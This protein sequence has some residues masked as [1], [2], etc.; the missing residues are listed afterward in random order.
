MNI[1]SAFGVKANQTDQNLVGGHIILHSLR[2]VSF[3]VSAVNLFVM[4]SPLLTV[5]KES[6]FKFLRVVAAVDA[7]F[8]LLLFSIGLQTNQCGTNDQ[9]KCSLTL[10]FSFLAVLSE[11]L[12]S[13]LALLNIQ[14]EIFITLRKILLISSSKWHVVRNANVRT[15]LL[16]FG[17]LS[18]IVCLP[19]LLIFKVVRKTE[20][21]FDLSRVIL[22]LDR[23]TEAIRITAVCPV[24]LLLTV[25]ATVRYHRYFR[26]KNHRFIRSGDIT[27]TSKTKK[28]KI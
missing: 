5:Q 16:F 25:M 10:E 11:Y 1:S 27:S 17:F 28:L 4:S 12:A 23:L 9:E 3:T 2:L 26:M 15:V 19:K 24:L 14:I 18:L 8:S 20:D 13:S 21:F 7:I 6:L 22:W